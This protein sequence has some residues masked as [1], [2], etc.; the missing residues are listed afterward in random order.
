MTCGSVFKVSLILLVIS[1][2]LMPIHFAKKRINLWE[3][4]SP[5][6]FAKS[7]SS[8]ASRYRRFI[9]VIPATSSRLYPQVSL[10]RFRYLPIVSISSLIKHTDI[11]HSLCR[12]CTV[13]RCCNHFFKCSKGFC[14]II[15]LE[16]C[17]AKVKVDIHI[18]L[19][20]LLSLFI[21]GNCILCHIH[22]HVCVTEPEMKNSDFRLYLYC[23]IKLCPG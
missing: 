20:P 17:Q 11:L 16:I 1:S 15:R 12:S 4:V 2:S 21:C 23:L 19:I 9:L 10:T 5:G 22:F 8:I 13:R 6:I 3:N 7:S 18:I 14:V